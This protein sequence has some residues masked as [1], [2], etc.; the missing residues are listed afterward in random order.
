[1]KADGGDFRERWDN[2]GHEEDD[3]E[4]DSVQVRRA[5]QRGRGQFVDE[6][7]IH[8]RA[9]HGG[10]GCESF[11]SPSPS[12]RKPT[13]GDGGDGGSVYILADAT[14]SALGGSSHVVA[15]GSGRHGGSSGLTGK[16]GKDAC[17]RVPP[18]TLVSLLTDHS[19]H[20]DRNFDNTG[21]KDWWELGSYDSDG[22]FHEYETTDADADAET[23][24][25]ADADADPAATRSAQARQRLKKRRAERAA[26]IDL[27]ASG[28]AV[29]VSRGGRGGR[30]N[31]ASI[32]ASKK[33]GGAGGG[34]AAQATP[35]EP[36]E[37]AWL[38]LE[39]A[40]LADV[41]LVGDLPK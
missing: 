13:G 31:L 30:G 41:A 8:A 29:R 32:S 17:L 40:L 9:G 33:R 24:T 15:A 35:G 26:A 1:M 14:L 25:V 34:G 37:E 16:R 4:D 6:V 19:D 18:G 7:R 22:F 10:N 23:D 5:G 38:R 39:L 27:S 28:Q 3:C 20:S 2:S 12:V 21:R 11:E 36:G